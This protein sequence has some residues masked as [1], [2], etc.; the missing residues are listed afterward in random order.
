MNRPSEPADR[1]LPLAEQLA[2]GCGDFAS[3]L[4]W[5]TFMK[6]LPFYYTD[7]F[8]LSATA[9]GGLLL[10]SRI[11]DGINNPIVGA[12]ADRT[13][14]RWGKF[15]PFILFGCVPFVIFG[16]LTF[17]TPDLSTSG[18]LL[19]AY[20]TYNGLMVLYTIV[21][22]PYTAMLGVMTENPAARTRLSSIKF[23]FAFS[24][25]MVI[26]ATLLPLAKY[27]GDDGENPQK[28]WQL[29]FVVVGFVALV[30][31]LITFFGTKERI[32]AKE[33]TAS[34]IARDIKLLVTNKPWVLLFATTFTFILFVATRSSVFTHYFKYY[35]LAG[36]PSKVRPLFGIDMSFDALV[37][38][39]NT[40]GQAF[41]VLGVLLTATIAGKIPKRLL[42]VVC[43]LLTI[44]S[45]ASYYVIPPEQIDLLFV[46]DVLGTFTSGPL[47]VLLWA[48]YADTADYGE[49]TSGR[50]TT[51]LVFSASTMGQKLGWAIGAYVAFQLLGSVGFEANVLPSAAVKESLVMLVSLAPSALG[52]LSIVIFLF[53]PL[54]DERVSAIAA[55]L[56][57]RRAQATAS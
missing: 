35:V 7:V 51:G 37:S 23:I 30:F 42:F 53:Y 31:F 29:T 8:G 33:D 5:Q 28:G 12:W 36:D 16:V 24:A 48:M 43:F 40:G 44:L 11:F 17:T 27:L 25:G 45:T 10:F 19:W 54:T 50:R 39:F 47:P 18:K 21:N 14:T 57:Q 13:T 38:A 56:K 32:A 4:F 55:D 52:L 6:Y 20:V 2:Y 15:R 34:S 46:M 9:L 3:V 1:Q 41:A 26:S 22:I 49:W